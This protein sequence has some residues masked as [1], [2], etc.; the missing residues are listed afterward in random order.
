MNVKLYYNISFNPGGVQLSK[1]VSHTDI[2]VSGSLDDDNIQSTHLTLL[3]PIHTLQTDVTYGC[4]ITVFTN[5][6]EPNIIKRVFSMTEDGIWIYS[7]FI[8]N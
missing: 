2:F 7:Q 6:G 8:L 3:I 5:A 4:T 1:E